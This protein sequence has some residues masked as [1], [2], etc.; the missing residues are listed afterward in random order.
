MKYLIG[1]V[2]SIPAY[3]MSNHFIQYS[4]PNSNISYNSLINA[5]LS[6]VVVGL[7]GLLDIKE[8]EKTSLSTYFG[9]GI[10]LSGFVFFI[11]NI[12]LGGTESNFTIILLCF[13]ITA[14][15][16]LAELVLIDNKKGN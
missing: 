12:Q 15:F 7:F 1:V 9:V 4:T 6:W 3:F 10:L 2:I 5:I 8:K 11:S 16:G 14:I 13:V